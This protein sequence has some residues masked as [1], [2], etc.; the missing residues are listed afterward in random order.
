MM[1]S[2][3]AT[4]SFSKKI[5]VPTGTHELQN[6]A[7]G[8]ANQQAGVADVTCPMGGRRKGEGGRQRLVSLGW[9]RTGRACCLGV[10]AGPADLRECARNL[11][12]SSFPHQRQNQN[13]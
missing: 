11:P 9:R 7:I 6:I 2:N 1:N 10:G 5:G 13:P 8:L 3:A 4:F 12:P